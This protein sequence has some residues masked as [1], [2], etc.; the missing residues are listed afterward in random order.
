MINVCKASRQDSEAV[1]KLLKERYDFFSL[2]EASR[3]FEIEYLN[4]HFRVA[5]DDGHVVGL[6][7]WR[8]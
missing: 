4:Q 6:I 3:V 8:P 5:K 7:G 1:S 2:K